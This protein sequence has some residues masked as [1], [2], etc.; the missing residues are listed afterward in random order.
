TPTDNFHNSSTG[1]WGNPIATSDGTLL[2]QITYEFVDDDNNGLVVGTPI[3]LTGKAGDKVTP[4]LKVPDGYILAPNQQM[5]GEYTLKDSNAPVLI[6]LKHPAKSASL[7]VKYVDQDTGKE[8][9]NTDLKQDGHEGDAITYSTTDTIKKLQSEGYTV[10]SDEFTG[11]AGSKLSADNNGKT[12][13]VTVKK[14]APEVKNGKQTI[15]F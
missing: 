2:T 5:P 15:N 1:V 11:K 12:Y 9:P 4:D 14:Q 10:V 3:T 13:V 6:H 7:T 8:I